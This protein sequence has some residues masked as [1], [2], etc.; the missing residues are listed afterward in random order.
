M[1]KTMVPHGWSSSSKGM[2][3]NSKDDNNNGRW[4]ERP[5]KMHHVQRAGA[6]RPDDHVLDCKILHRQIKRVKFHRASIVSGKTTNIEETLNHVRS[7]QNI[8][9]VK[10][11]VRTESPTDVI[12][13][14]EP[15]HT[16]IEEGLDEA[17]GRRVKI[18]PT[19][20]VVWCVALESVTQS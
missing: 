17:K 4:S 19:N 3:N 13:R 5:E 14:E 10:G 8:V 15:L 20:G 1:I 16:T 2:G 6:I 11:S 12:V 18:L 7:K 9:K